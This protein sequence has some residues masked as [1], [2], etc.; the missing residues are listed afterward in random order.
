MRS[1]AI[2]HAALS[3]G[4]AALTL[5][6]AAAQ[7]SP[8]TLAAQD[9]TLAK[10]ARIVPSAL[11]IPAGA[12]ATLLLELWV[13]GRGEHPLVNVRES[14]DHIFAD[15]KTLSALGLQ[16][17]WPAA[18]ANGEVDLAAIDGMKAVVDQA[19][20]RLMLDPPVAALPR[21]LYDVGR[22][23]AP[24]P[25]QSD[26]G[27][28]LRYDLSATDAD[29]RR[30][31]QSL[32]GGGNFGL[33]LFTPDARFTSTGFAAADVTGVHGA[34]LD[35]ALVF[36]NP[37]QLNHLSFGDAIN[38]VPGF[39]RAVRFGGVEFA[40]DFSLR[41]DL[42]TR[43]LPEFFGQSAVPATVD[44]YSGAARVYEQQVAPGPFDILNLP[45]L[46]GEGTATI[47]TRD[48]LGRET[49]QTLSLYT[50]EDLLAP[51]LQ[52]YAVDLGFLRS[53][54]GL[55][56]LG[57]DAPLVSL[58]YRRG[59]SNILTLESHGEAAPGLGMISGG[60]DIALGSLG[61]LGGDVAASGG[62]AGGGL[63]LSL[64]ANARAGPVTFFG[65]G[66]SASA[67]YR[68]L[69]SLGSGGVA[70][71][72]QR[73]QAGIAIGLAPYGALALSWIGSKY[74][75]LAANDFVSASWSAT[76]PS[77]LFI[78][79]TALQDLTRNQFS[80][81]ISVGIPIGARGLASVSAANDNGRSSGIGLYDNPADP[82]GGLGWRLL[83]GYQDG[84]R[85]EG[86]ATYIGPNIGLDGGVSVQDG[87][88]A[89]RADAN[90]AL[91][92]MRGGIFATHDPGGAFALVETGDPHVRIYREN[93]LEAV[94]DA[95]GQALLVGLLPYT[96]NHVSIEPR[97]FSFDTL[98]E[99]TDMFVAP[100]SGSGA[101]ISFRPASH[102]ALVAE[103][104]RGIDIPTPLGA[105][106]MLDD[107]SEPMILGHGGEVFIPDFDKPVGADIDLGNARCRVFITPGTR[108]G[109]M[110]R[111]EPLL[112]LR[113][114][115]GAY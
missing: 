32:G 108:K 56:N 95:N 4:A 29:A 83:G 2:F 16:M 80:A 50:G 28:V 71:P 5:Q 96:A 61:I 81:Q 90:G 24:V 40:S 12:G 110:P 26:T 52:D 49:T 51:G 86:D 65:S 15:G 107:R 84:L 75:G 21:Q 30:F 14:G 18:D 53:K 13:A 102:N 11:G 6:D 105:A 101:V 78:A 42:D 89:L 87:T 54:Y 93:R 33:E 19:S 34:R 38:I 109:G 104:T 85:A 106:V 113:E 79:A 72:R 60:G 57:Y 44:V 55:E 112:C 37:G 31:G 35:S 68:D 92:V 62:D 67:F 58:S 23:P 73:F 17:T 74:Q 46:S 98:V 111:T 100:R 48:V 36:D 39:G 43:P 115:D 69:A 77:G 7:I 64:N 20:Q 9:G 88:P 47:V 10:N 103:I 99:K 25:A 82:D 45:I 70:P 114:A 41:P 3:L 76:L 27:A 63:L 94:S 91:I 59:I 8:V 22:G 97:D 1:T 66:Q